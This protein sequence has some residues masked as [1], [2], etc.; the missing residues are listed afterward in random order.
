MLSF[1]NKITVIQSFGKFEKNK[2]IYL[3]NK[4]NC[5]LY[6]QRLVTKGKI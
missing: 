3:G 4:R 2:C 1:F 5:S 6:R